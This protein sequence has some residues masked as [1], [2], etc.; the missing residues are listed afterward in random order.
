MVD[1]GESTDD[2]DYGPQEH[3]MKQWKVEPIRT[4]D[5][6]AAGQATKGFSVTGMIMKELRDRTRE[7]KRK[8]RQEAE[9]EPEP[10]QLTGKQKRAMYNA[11]KVRKIGR[12]FYETANVKNRNRDRVRAIDPDLANRGHTKKVKR[13]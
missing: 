2:F 7:A 13:K 12:H 6:S 3:Q 11:Q 1:E 10:E 9:D 4:G 8:S 5:S